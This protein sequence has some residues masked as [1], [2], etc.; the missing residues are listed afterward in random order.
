[1]DREDLKERVLGV[2][3]RPQAAAPAGTSREVLLALSELTRRHGGDIPAQGNGDLTGFELRVFSQNG[4]DGVLAEIL[5][6]TGVSGGCFVEFGSGDGSEN[7]C[8]VLADVR[9]WE[10]LYMDAG[11]QQFELLSHRYTGHPAVR[12]AQTM[13][14]PDTID[15]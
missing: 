6:R 4:E 10:G 3:R 8:R 12:V 13:V 7:N 15:A 14:T 11:E 2:L 1:M 9:G 5:R